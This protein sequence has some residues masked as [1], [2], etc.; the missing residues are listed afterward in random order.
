MEKKDVVFL[1]TSLI[2][3][4]RIDKQQPFPQ[5]ENPRAYSETKQDFTRWYDFL[6][7]CYEG[8]KE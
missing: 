5:T 3:A 6:H 2:F 8:C 4:N 1:A 7:D